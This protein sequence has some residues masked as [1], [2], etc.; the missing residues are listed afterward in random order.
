MV[1]VRAANIRLH[2]PLLHPCK[3]YVDPAQLESRCWSG[4]GVFGHSPACCRITVDLIPVKDRMPVNQ[5]AYPCKVC[6]FRG[7]TS[8]MRSIGDTKPDQNMKYEDSLSVSLMNFSWWVSQKG[9]PSA[10]GAS[11]LVISVHMSSVDFM[12][13]SR[14]RSL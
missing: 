9:T 3:T 4:F 6:Q 11:G 14:D 8:G 13:N 10:A 5:L 1:W 7:E 12:M 2:K